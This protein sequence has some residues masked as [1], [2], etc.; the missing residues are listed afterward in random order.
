MGYEIPA[1]IG[2][3]L[4][5]SE[6]EVVVFIGDGS[7]PDDELRNCHRRL[8]RG[9][10]LTVVVVDNHGLPEHSRL[11]AEYRDAALWS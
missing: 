6:R 4:A 8:L 2:V 11:A 1:G 7:L 9:W 3:K 10:T 5:E